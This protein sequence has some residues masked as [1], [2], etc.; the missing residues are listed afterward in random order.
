MQKILLLHGALGSETDFKVLKEMLSGE[1][2]MYTMNFNG[3]GGKPLNE[4]TFSIEGFANEVV[5]FL[6][7]RQLK[8]IF[9]F[10]YSMGGYVGL[11]LAKHFPNRID[12]LFTLAT[13]L[14]WTKEGAAKET[15]MLQPDSIEQKVTKYA[16]SLALLHGNSWKDLMKATAAM[17]VQL[18]ENPRLKPADF[19][20]IEIPVLMAV[21]DKDAMVSIEETTSAYRA[22]PNAQLLVLP[23][24]VHPIG[25]VNVE[26]LAFHIRNYFL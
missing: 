2:E 22:L 12:K 3:H 14:N 18:G 19:A 4:E 9:I 8:T 16:A 25:R 23:D 6:D 11:Y 24:T 5:A 7:E 21:G 17:M 13:K 1:F 10:G 15:Q 20:Q 26:V